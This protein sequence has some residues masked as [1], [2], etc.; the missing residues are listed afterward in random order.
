M[1]LPSRLYQ[2]ITMEISSHNLRA[3]TQAAS[4][5]SA[6]YRSHRA[7][8][9]IFMDRTAYRLAYL[10]VR[11]P[12]TF[13]AIWAVFM[14]MRRLLSGRPITSLLDLGA[15]PGT[16]GWAAT[17]VFEEIQQITL[18]EQDEELIRLGKSLA[19]T[20]ENVVLEQAD[21]VQANLCV[22][23]SFPVHDL[24]VSS[25]TLG[26]FEPPVAREILKTAWK[27]ARTA[28]VIIEPG[29]MRGFELIRLLRSDLIALGGQVIAPCP[30]QGECPIPPHDWCHFSQR[31]DRSAFH[32]RI[33]LGIHG[34]EDEKFSY[35][36]VSKSPFKPVQARVI[37][38]PLRH[39]GHTRL[40]L[41]TRDGLQT[42][43]VTR[44]D[45]ERWRRARKIRWGDEWLGLM[46]QGRV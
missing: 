44:S 36:V 28:L 18:L 1:Q 33:K 45:N 41:C 6:Q 4:E 17:E 37:R 7:A 11:M 26:E 34:Y 42:I 24:V 31:L 8:K 39:S 19:R 43:T 27:A 40:L 10:A 9:G 35:L 25:Y 3:L 13:A 2:A 38:H 23:E 20:G 46:G 30:H 12:A 15:G 29:T 32:R 22:I 5:L 14:E 21:W 16:V